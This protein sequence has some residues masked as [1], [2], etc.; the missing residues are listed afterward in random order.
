[1]NLETPSEHNFWDKKVYAEI[2]NQANPTP[3][4]NEWCEY[5]ESCEYFVK[6][7]HKDGTRNFPIE[8]IEKRAKNA[9]KFGIGNCSEQSNLA[10]CLLQEYPKNGDAK[11]PPLTNNIRFERITI[12]MP[13]DHSFIVINRDPH[14]DLNNIF[15]WGKD[16][17]ILDC[18]MRDVFILEDIINAYED[19][20]E[21]TSED[22]HCFKHLLQYQASFYLINPYFYGYIGEGHTPRWYEK[23]QLKNQPTEFNA[24][25]PY[26]QRTINNQIINEENV[27]WVNE[28][29]V[30]KDSLKR[31]RQQF[32]DEDEELRSYTRRRL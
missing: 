25:I 21:S 18:W 2:P 30:K 27:P 8:Q 22:L 28:K 1:M 3:T 9:I 29:S 26:Q 15:T 10:F 23:R 14:S 20:P 6:K 4:L 16:T 7:F 11:L 13:G 12:P 31:V 17:V 19:N 5:L 24:W 32:A